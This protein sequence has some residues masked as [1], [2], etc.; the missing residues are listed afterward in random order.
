MWSLKPP[1]GKLGLYLERGHHEYQSSISRCTHFCRAAARTQ[2]KR[3]RIVSAN[4]NSKRPSHIRWSKNKK[5]VIRHFSRIKRI[6]RHSDPQRVGSVRREII[7]SKQK[8]SRR[9][10]RVVERGSRKHF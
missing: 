10:I 8:Q 1:C 7:Q 6:F 4:R 5:W 3:R 2:H 9:E